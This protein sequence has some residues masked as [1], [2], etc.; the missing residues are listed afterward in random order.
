MIFG[1]KAG[2]LMA[3]AVTLAAAPDDGWQAYTAGRSTEAVGIW[4]REAAAGDAEAAFGLGLAFDL[5]QGVGQDEAR[6]CFWY[7]RAGEAGIT[8]AAF[9]TAVMLDQGRCGTRDPAAVAAWYGRAAAAGHARAE[10]D[11]AQLYQDGDG[12]PHNP[13]EAVAWYRLAAANG[14]PAAA[15]QADAL[16]HARPS[17]GLALQPVSAV[18]PVNETLPD[19]GQSV[20]FVWAAPPQSGPVRFF[21]EVDALSRDGSGD[22]SREIAARYVDQCATT[23]ILPPGTAQ[24]AWRVYTVS[25]AEHR[26]VV[27]GWTRFQVTGRTDR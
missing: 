16:S 27:D 24:Y 1:L 3:S 19:R 14:L 26:Y 8:A 6:A 12:V 22:G 21:L 25:A 11:L 5:G 10:Y 17:P 15:E 23:V 13:D 4:T 2:L 20:P 9:N 7:Q 18:T